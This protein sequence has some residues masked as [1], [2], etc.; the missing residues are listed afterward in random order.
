MMAAC[1]GLADALVGLYQ[2]HVAAQYGGVFV[3]FFPDRGHSPAQRGTVHYVVVDK[4]ESVEDLQSGG[5]LQHLRLHA[6]AEH[7]VGG[8]AQ[9]GTD[10]LATYGNHISQR[11]VKAGGILRKTD[12]IFIKHIHKD[13]NLMNIFAV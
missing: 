10:A 5:G 4:G 13:S 8:Q 9:T 11:I 6:S 1:G 2:H 12:T 3:P 7:L